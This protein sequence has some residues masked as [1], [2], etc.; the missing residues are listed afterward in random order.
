MLRVT[1]LRAKSAWAVPEMFTPFFAEIDLS[2]CIKQKQLRDCFVIELSK[3][4]MQKH[5][6]LFV[7][8][9]NST[10]ACDFIIDL[11]SAERINKSEIKRICIRRIL[12]K[13][14]FRYGVGI[15][16]FSA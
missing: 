12:F 4:V 15:E 14:G 16:L 13:L 6:A 1:G 5:T 9:D 10:F 8:S 7:N 11:I 3:R 2:I